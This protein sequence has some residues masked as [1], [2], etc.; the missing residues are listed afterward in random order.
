MFTFFVIAAVALALGVAYL[1][2]ENDRLQSNIIQYQN[3]ISG[4]NIKIERLTEKNLVQSRKLAAAEKEIFDWESGAR[5]RHVHGDPGLHI[6]TDSE[7]VTFNCP[8]VKN[9]LLTVN[10]TEIV[11]GPLDLEIA[12]ALKKP[13]K[14][15]RKK[16][17]KKT[18]SKKKS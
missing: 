12:K 13:A 7:N 5:E 1:L 3:T 8:P 16:S 11:T 10:E 14:K 15:P 4:F 2:V 6:T 18:P 17:E 9:P